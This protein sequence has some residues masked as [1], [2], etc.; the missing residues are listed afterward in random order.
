MGSD[1]AALEGG[2]GLQTG[3]QNINVVPQMD[4]DTSSSFRENKHGKSTEN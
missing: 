2:G 3:K 1:F 4:A